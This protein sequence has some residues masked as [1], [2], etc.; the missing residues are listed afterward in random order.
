MTNRAAPSDDPRA[1]DRH[2]VQQVEHTHGR[3]QQQPTPRRGERGAAI[4]ELAIV[5]SL[6]LVLIFGIITYAYMM[7]FR[8]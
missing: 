1:V 4:V 7:S 5:A 2:G 8:Q 6:L 3:A